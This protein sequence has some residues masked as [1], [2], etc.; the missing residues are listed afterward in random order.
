MLTKV[1]YITETIDKILCSPIK[2][3]IIIISYI[4]FYSIILIILITYNSF[5]IIS[6]VFWHV[7]ISKVLYKQIIQKVIFSKLILNI[8]FL[9]FYNLIFLHYK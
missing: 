5:N 4:R 3:I 9:S 2:S 7:P 1:H 6:F 8:P